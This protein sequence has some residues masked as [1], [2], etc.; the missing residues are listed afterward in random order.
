MWYDAWIPYN[1]QTKKKIIIPHL[2]DEIPLPTN[3]YFQNNIPASYKYNF[4]SYTRKYYQR[5][6]F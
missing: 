1:N 6:E 4:I 3:L 5:T 2:M